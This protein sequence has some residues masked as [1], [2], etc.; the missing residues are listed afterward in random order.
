MVDHHLVHA[1]AGKHERRRRGA[2]AQG[3]K[4]AGRH[5]LE[6]VEGMMD[7]PIGLRAQGAACR[8]GRC[9]LGLCTS[10]CVCTCLLTARTVRPERCA[11]GGGK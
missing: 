5:R 3:R 7:V 11:H 1:C 9:M 2:G 4:E 6:A 10:S 8:R